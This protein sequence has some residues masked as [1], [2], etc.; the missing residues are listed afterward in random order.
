M[1]RG[2]DLGFSYFGCFLFEHLISEGK[3]EVYRIETTSAINHF[4]CSPSMSN[5][6]V[7]QF[8]SWLQTSATSLDNF[9]FSSFSDDC[10]ENR[11]RMSWCVLVAEVS[12]LLLFRVACFLD[13]NSFVIFFTNRPWPIQIIVQTGT[14]QR[15]VPFNVFISFLL[16]IISMATSQ[17]K[18]PGK[19]LE[20]SS[21]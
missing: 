3:I 1:I 9:P 11:R 13:G 20:S 12:P 21:C 14:E 16:V 8:S 10:E 19:S 17:G 7:S 6:N 2:I 4:F 18:L 5:E 15:L